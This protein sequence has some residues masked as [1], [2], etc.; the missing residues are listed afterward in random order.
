MEA[1]LLVPTPQPC[2]VVRGSI[3]HIKEA[4]LV[5]E[6]KIVTTMRA[7]EAPLILLSAFY[8]FNMHYTEHC[9]NFYTFFEVIFFNGQ[10]PSKKPRLTA[11]LARLQ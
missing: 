10:R 4:A 9:S 2:L 8:A 6:K 1:V 11:L 3:S 5:V 7:E